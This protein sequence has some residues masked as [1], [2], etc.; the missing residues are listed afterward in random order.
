VPKGELLGALLAYRTL[1]YLVP[2]IVASVTYVFVEARA[3]ALAHDP[4][5]PPDLR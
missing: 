4:L 1:Y 2:L 5:R 3:K